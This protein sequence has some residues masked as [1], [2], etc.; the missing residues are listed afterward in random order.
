MVVT[1]LVLLTAFTVVY[2][3]TYTSIRA[4]NERKLDEVSATY[5]ITRFSSRVINEEFGHVEFRYGDDGI[6][7]FEISNG[8]YYD[9]ALSFDIIVG[10][11]GEFID[12]DS[13]LNL[14]VD[15]YK[16]AAEGAWENWNNSNSNSLIAVIS[17]RTWLYRINPYRI[18]IAPDSIDAPLYRQSSD[19]YKI[20]FLDI[21]ESQK[22]LSDLLLTF[23]FVGI[24][25]LAVIFIVSYVFANRSI[26]PISESWE[27][28]KRFVA[29]ASHELKTPLTTIMTNC[30]ALKANE[31]ETV[32]SQS[33]WINSIQIGADRMSKLIGN[34]LTLARAEGIPPQLKKQS[35][36]LR[37]LIEEVVEFFETT[38]REKN[39]RITQNIDVSK[40]IG[41]EDYVRQILVILY[42]NAVKYTNKDGL[43]E[44]S[45][46]KTKG[47]V[48]ITVKNTGAGIT[49]KDLPNIF[50]R[51]YRAD[52]ARSNDDGSYGLGLSI[53]R[54][55]AEQI[56]GKIA[57][58][59]IEGEWAEFTLMF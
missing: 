54:N 41:Y 3:T 53:S 37:D 35:F 29:D 5:S 39:L 30:D 48:R 20:T 52:T 10:K 23:L 24:G 19:A 22:T 13:L 32:I 44:I 46:Y 55:I 25:M 8:I 6:T 26:R 21:T 9:F 1:S 57:A 4:E 45:A 38:A 49:S 12:V 51:F 40:V 16:S 2:L 33:E 31:H 34:L 56:G 28:Q 59:S 58:K 47:D 7:D 42:D 18:W 17:D 43:I 50:D 15:E 14:S 27:K 11:S 36:S